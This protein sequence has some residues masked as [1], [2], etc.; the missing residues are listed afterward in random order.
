[1]MGFLYDEHPT[2]SS[3]PFDRSR[4]RRMNPNKMWH[5]HMRNHFV[6]RAMT[7]SA[8]TAPRDKIQASRELAV[9]EKKMTF[10]ERMP[11]FDRE[12][13]NKSQRTEQLLWDRARETKR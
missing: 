1:M 4:L 11:G 7:M 12:E 6:L 2:K 13:A 3:E 5:T 9:C 8:T 10:W